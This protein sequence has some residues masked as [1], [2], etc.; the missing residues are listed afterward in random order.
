MLP[1]RIVPFDVAPDRLGR[2]YP[3]STDAQADFERA[4]KNLTDVIERLTRDQLPEPPNRIDAVLTLDY[5][6]A[7]RNQLLLWQGGF[8]FDGSARELLQVTSD[9]ME[10]L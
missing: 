8:S 9:L 4:M 6:V 5:L 1:P 10:R 3:P 7:V 2:L